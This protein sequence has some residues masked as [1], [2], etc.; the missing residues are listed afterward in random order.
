MYRTAITEKDRATATGNMYRRLGEIWMCGF[1]D[2]RAD[3]QT[4]KQTDRHTDR[5][6]HSTTIPSSQTL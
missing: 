1:R 3:R 5:I 2:V 4:N 6:I